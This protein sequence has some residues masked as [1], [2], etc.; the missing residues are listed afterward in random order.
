MK[1]TVPIQAYGAKCCDLDL[2]PRE[3]EIFTTMSRAIGNPI[4]FEIVK[5]LNTHAGCITGDLVDVLPIAQATTS[6]HLRVLKEAGWI[7]GIVEG[8]ATRY[9]LN[10]ER[11][12]TFKD[13]V[14]RL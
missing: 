4:R 10:A 3:E 11:V 1:R 8:P 6:Q 2:T 12:R 5:Y 14:S 13:I 9:C 7:E